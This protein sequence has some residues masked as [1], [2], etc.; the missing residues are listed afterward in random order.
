MNKDYYKTL[1]I[2]RSASQDEVKKA[3]RSLSK[4]HHPDK[5][6][7]EN[8]FKELSEAYDTLS[9]TQK[10]EQY[11]HKLDHPF[12]GGNERNMEDVF[13]QFFQQNQRRTVRRGGNLSIPLTISLDDV[14]FGKTKKLRYN[15][16]INCQGCSGSGGQTQLCGHCQGRGVVEQAVG[17]AFFRQ[18]RQMQCPAC[19]GKGKKILT[20][21][22]QCNGE[23]KTKREDVV[24][25][26]IPH[27][28]MT[29]Q[30]Y[31]F[32]GK[33]EEIENGQPGDLQIQVVIARHQHFTVVER[34][35]IYEPEINILDILL[36]RIVEVPYFGAY[37]NTNIPPCSSPNTIFKVKGKGLRKGDGTSGNILVKPQIKMPKK[38]T[39][40]EEDVLRNLY[41]SEN[42]IRG[43]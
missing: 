13:N 32:R 15:R 9:D 6:G 24:D 4:Q 17:N 1:N 39:R 10:R 2:N 30:V 40:Q 25:F 23:G 19:N 28:L 14:F 38:L 7:D 16:N 11:N 41:N 26:P 20:A 35:L 18:I 12:N 3:F 21:C 27:D 31:T 8:I 33:G 37:L 36:G 42:F 43:I 29:G 5:G 22:H 34:D